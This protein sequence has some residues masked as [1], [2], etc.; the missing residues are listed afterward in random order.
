M[1]A[2]YDAVA[3]QLDGTE[4][5]VAASALRDLNDLRAIPLLVRHGIMRHF[6][7]LRHLQRGRLANSELL[8]L[9]D[10]KDAEVRWRA[11]YALA[12]SGDPGLASIVKRLARDEASQARAQA[13]NIAF[14]LPSHAF[15]SSRFN[16]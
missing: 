16:G 15:I 11:A 5:D 4:E 2:L 10:E 1:T 14:L 3:A 12:E 8:A 9:L 7:V 6:E 13:A